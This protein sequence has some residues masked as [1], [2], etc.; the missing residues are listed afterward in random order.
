MW[1]ASQASMTRADGPERPAAAAPWR[2]R[3]RWCDCDDSVADVPDSADAAEALGVVADPPAAARSVVVAASPSPAITGAVPARGPCR[4]RGERARPCLARDRAALRLAAR[5]S[6]QPALAHERDLLNPEFVLLGDGAA[7]GREDRCRVHA[8]AAAELGDDPQPF[9]VVRIEAEGRHAARSNV[10]V[11]CF[12]RPLDVERVVVP[13][14]DDHELFLAAMHVQLAVAEEPEVA[15]PQE[16]DRA[17]G[18]RRAEEALRF[19]R[20]APVAAHHPIARHPHFADLAGRQR[21]APIGVDDLHAETGQRAAAARDRDGGRRTRFHGG[22]SRLLRCRWRCR[23]RL[24]LVV[25]QRLCVDR[26]RP[27]ALVAGAHRDEQALGE[28]VAGEERRFA[29]AADRERLAEPIDR[30]RPDRLGAAGGERPA[31]QV[32]LRPILGLA[33]LDEQLIREVRCAALLGPD[34]RDGLE[35]SHR[36]LEEGERRHHRRVAAGEDRLEHRPEQPHVVVGREPAHPARLAGVAER[37]GDGARSL[38]ISWPWLIIAPRGAAGGARGV[39]EELPAGRSAVCGRCQRSAAA[40]SASSMSI[41]VTPGSAARSVA[42]ADRLATI[43]LKLCRRR[44]RDDRLERTR[45]APGPRR[46][47]GGHCNRAGRAKHGERWPPRSRGRAARAAVDALGRG[48]APLPARRPGPDAAIERREGQ[49]R[50][51]ELAVHEVRVGEPIRL[52]LNAFGEQVDERRRQAVGG[53]GCASTGW[54]DVATA[55]TLRAR[56]G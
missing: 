24:R 41:V 2:G 12:D 47:V 5:G 31:G 56:R 17:A 27:D 13:A 32:E 7:D 22:H 49:V 51:F 30:L 45:R 8:R 15:R 33:V 42:R 28:A 35:P 36:P 40:G 29:E 39:L 9:L 4:R 34:A 20:S 21:H 10:R 23:W 11:R 54:W 38:I 46:R 48:P 50:G 55:W 43:A 37:R 6:G 44:I 25:A 16:L 26:D 3:R 18:Q 52:A 14:A 19:G 1:L 53:L